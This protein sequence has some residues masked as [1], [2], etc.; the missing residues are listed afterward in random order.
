MFV[1]AM[2]IAA[3]NAPAEPSDDAT[4]HHPFD[5]VAKWVAVFDDPGRDVWQKPDAVI[6]ALGVAPG[7]TVETASNVRIQRSASWASVAPGGTSGLS[8]STTSSPTS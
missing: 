3:L 7:M 6:H 8:S 1:I 5:D 2:L 4:V